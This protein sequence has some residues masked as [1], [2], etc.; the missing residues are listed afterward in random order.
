VVFVR[1]LLLDLSSSAPS[2]SETSANSGGTPLSLRSVP[3][4]VCTAFHARS[5][6]WA[7]G[8]FECAGQMRGCLLVMGLVDRAERLRQALEP[9]RAHEPIQR[10][11]GCV[12]PHTRQRPPRPAAPNPQRAGSIGALDLGGAR[13]GRVE[14]AAERAAAWRATIAP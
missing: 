1:V 9:R 7:V 2:R 6:A 10:S 14:P 8:G 13:P 4:S 12:W 11:S 3:S 5:K